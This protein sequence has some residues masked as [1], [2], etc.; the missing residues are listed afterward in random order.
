MIL[1]KRIKSQGVSEEERDFIIGTPMKRTILVQHI[2]HKGIAILKSCF[3]LDFPMFIAFVLNNCCGK[4]KGISCRYN[5]QNFLI[6]RSIHFIVIDNRVKQ[7]LLI[8]YIV[9]YLGVHSNLSITV[10]VVMMFHSREIL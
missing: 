10:H 4:L 2:P 7:D 5:L 8:I 3:F 9:K 1:D 6:H